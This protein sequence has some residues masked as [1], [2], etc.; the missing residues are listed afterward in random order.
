[1][2][3]VLGPMQAAMEILVAYAAMAAQEDREENKDEKEKGSKGWA[4]WKRGGLIGAAAV[5]G[6]A[7]LALTGG[8]NL[9]IVLTSC[10]AGSR[11][12]LLRHDCYSLSGLAAPAIAAGLSA[13]A[14][15]LGTIVPVIGSTGFAA[16][17]AVA[18]S[19]AGSVAV[20]ASFGGTSYYQKHK[21]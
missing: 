3:L 13:L 2:I 6:G 10:A 12:K 4:K 18:A 9:S 8:S 19:T 7:L 20:A 11:V 1:M 14:P 16:A 17:A 15:T 5:T 21:L